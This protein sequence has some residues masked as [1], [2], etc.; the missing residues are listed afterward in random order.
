[1]V[2]IGALLF[3]VVLISAVYLTAIQEI[4]KKIKGIPIGELDAE[5]LME[6]LKN[7]LDCPFVKEIGNNKKG[8][9]EIRCRFA[10]HDVRLEKGCLYIDKLAKKYSAHREIEE[11]WY[12]NKYIAKLFNPAEPGECEEFHNG[13]MK[14]L[15]I[16]NLSRI[17]KYAFYV[18]IVVFVVSAL[19]G[20]GSGQD[21]SSGTAG[22]KVAEKYYIGE[23]VTF[24]MENGGMI[25]VTLTDWGST[26]DMLEGELLYVD[27]TVENVGDEMLC[28]GDGLFNIY[29]DNYSVG[30]ISGDN[31]VFGEDISSGRK[32]SGTIYAECD[33]E[34]ASVIEVE[35]GDTVFVIK[36]ASTE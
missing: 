24:A 32:I 20:E 28:V 31:S 9:I 11:A 4:H 21:E 1:M 8:G 33:V 15:K 12:L 34:S 10:T 19:T 30:R 23:T 16:Y 13:F 27:Y 18:W 14:Y 2:T 5:D 7:E 22:Q 36:D 29:V 25:D 17:I 3:I 26:Y 35:C 6:K